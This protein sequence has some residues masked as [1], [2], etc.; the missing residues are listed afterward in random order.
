MLIVSRD[1][2]VVKGYGSVIDL[3][4]KPVPKVGVVQKKSV[5]Q[6]QTSAMKS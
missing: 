3:N 4:S 6:E 2:N 5:A 1:P